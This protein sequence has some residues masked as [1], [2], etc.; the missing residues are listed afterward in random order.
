MT[1]APSVV[2]LREVRKTYLMGETEVHALDGLDLRITEGEFVAIMGPSGSGKSTLLNLLGCLDRPTSGAYFLGDRDVAT[3]S[4]NELSLVRSERVGFIFQSFNLIAALN[5]LENIEVPLF[6]AGCTGR[7][8]R[9]RSLEL[10][11]LVGL[12]DRGGHRPTELS[13]GQQQRVAIARALANDPMLILADEPTGNL[14]SRTGAEIM[15]IL[16]RLNQEG[17]TLIM[18]THEDDVA[19]QARR[20]VV[21][22]DGKI[23]DDRATARSAA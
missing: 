20:I 9:E 11:E 23:Q 14:D 10:A 4:D 15:A 21:L 5:V 3:M 6:Y 2:D 17:R 22:K 12:A 16:R 13:G 8:A 19:D 18:V 7:V 1:G